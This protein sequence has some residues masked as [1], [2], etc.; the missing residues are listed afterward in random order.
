MCGFHKKDRVGWGE[1]S[2]VGVKQVTGNF[3]LYAKN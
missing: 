2:M 3:I 1:M